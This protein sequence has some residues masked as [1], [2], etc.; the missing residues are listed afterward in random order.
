MK[1]T[2]LL[3]GF[4]VFLN[5]I[6]S[7]STHAQRRQDI[8]SLFR[9]EMQQ[10]TTRLKWRG[11]RLSDDTIYAVAL[12][13][14]S[15]SLSWGKETLFSLAWG[16]CKKVPTLARRNGQQYLNLVRDV[17]RN[18]EAKRYRDAIRVAIDNF[19]L[20]QIGCDVFLKEPVGRSF[21]AL[22]QPE[23]AFPIFAAPFESPGA[24][25][26]VV[27]LNRR[28]R[29]YAWEAA[30]KANLRREAIAFA[31]SLYLAPDLENQTPHTEALNYLQANNVD[32]DRV[33]MGVLQAPDKLHGLPAYAYAAVDLLTA[34][35][36]LKLLPFFLL[37]AESEDSYLRSRSIF[38]LGTLAYQNGEAQDN[39]WAER[40]L[41]RRPREYGISSTDRK[42]VEK[43][44]REGL[45]HDRHRV[46]AAAV[47][48]YALMAPPQAQQQ[49]QKML[50]DRAYIL[51]VP[52]D[53]P[54][55]TKIRRIEFPVREAAALAL[56]RFGINTE[57]ISGDYEGKAFDK[58]KRGGQDQTNDR[59]D[60][61]QKY[62]SPIHV[63]PADELYTSLPARLT[64]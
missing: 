63:T 28:F 15:W 54:V 1:R 36:N 52:K 27:D 10:A 13:G 41:G 35:V 39:A 4:L 57:T 42:R 11:D 23:Q 48:A 51:M 46:R 55:N 58:A 9:D 25:A 34:R 6:P 38:A 59:R 29:E 44:V 16:D 45:E 21:M 33:L 18:Y 24:N 17:Q 32:L 22:G 37:L 40:V 61:R 64:N 50:K 53:A 3:L 43:L 47:L 26:D 62:A 19:S 30:D 2:Q 14:T 12:S 7:L 49:L 5:L 20:E 31:L 60:L 56:E 8:S